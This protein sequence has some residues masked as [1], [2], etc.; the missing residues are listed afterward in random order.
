M[1]T[2]APTM[3]TTAKKRVPMSSLRRTSLTAGVFYLMI[4]SIASLA[5]VPLLLITGAG[6]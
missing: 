6:A 3:K 1:T 2:T 5:A 4:I